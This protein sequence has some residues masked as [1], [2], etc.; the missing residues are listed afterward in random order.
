MEKLRGPIVGFTSIYR[1][2]AIWTP[3]FWFVTW[4]KSA[5]HQDQYSF[6]SLP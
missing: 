1:I 2:F 3:V 4:R 5:F 6:F